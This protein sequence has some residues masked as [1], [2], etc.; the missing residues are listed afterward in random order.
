[1]ISISKGTGGIPNKYARSMWNQTFI[2]GAWVTSTPTDSLIS[3]TTD[4]YMFEFSAVMKMNQLLNSANYSIK[5][6]NDVT[7]PIYEI[8]KIDT[9]DGLAATPGTTLVAL[10]IPKADSGMVYE[11]SVNNLQRNDGM[12]IDTT[13]KQYYYHNWE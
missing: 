7:I 8:A 10:V 3:D 2:V 12:P 1:M 11:A 5:D 9:L 6:S 13:K 4:V